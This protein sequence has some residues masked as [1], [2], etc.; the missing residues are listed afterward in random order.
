MNALKTKKLS[1][2]STSSYSFMN[3]PSIAPA[4]SMIEEGG[5]V[6][7][8]HKYL[9]STPALLEKRTEHGTIRLERKSTH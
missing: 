8:N 1:P 2:N 3:V 5:N 9:A 7:R 6:L 4:H